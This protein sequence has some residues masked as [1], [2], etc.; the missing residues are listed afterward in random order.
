[1]CIYSV[2]TLQSM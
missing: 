1:M 2:V